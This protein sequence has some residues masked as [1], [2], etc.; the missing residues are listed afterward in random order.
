MDHGKHEPIPIPSTVSPKTRG[1]QHNAHRDNVLGE[2]EGAGTE[3]NHAAAPASLGHVDIVVWVALQARVVHLFIQAHSSAVQAH[4]KSDPSWARYNYDAANNTERNENTT[5]APTPASTT[6]TS[7]INANTVRKA[8]PTPTVL[9]ILRKVP[10]FIIV[11]IPV[12]G[13]FFVLVV[14]YRIYS[15]RLFRP[16]LHLFGSIPC[17]QHNNTASSTTHVRGARVR[18]EEAR[19]ADCVFL[20]LLYSEVHR[21]DSSQQQPRVERAQPGAFRVLVEV[22]LKCSKCCRK[23]SGRQ[24]GHKLG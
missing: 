14:A 18:L 23:Q 13:F 8:T 15:R 19:D 5:T 16:I 17:C 22:D 2:Y 12:D 7:T 20:L 11:N 21:L 9:Y 4:E 1:Q 10:C 24:G 6:T 3:A